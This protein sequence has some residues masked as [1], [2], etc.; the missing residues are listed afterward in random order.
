M[1]SALS[2]MKVIME[3]ALAPIK[4]AKEGKSPGGGGPA[5][6]PSALVNSDGECVFCLR[7]FC[8]LLKGGEMCRSAKRSLGFLR[9]KEN[10]TSEKDD[11]GADS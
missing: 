11:K 10:K 7:T 6:A 9:A 2:A 4:E 5:K 3:E 8:T 1:G